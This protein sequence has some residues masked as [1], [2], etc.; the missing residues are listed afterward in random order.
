MRKIGFMQGRL[1]PLVDG[2]IQAFPWS[3]WED[4]FIRGSQ[5]G[6]DLIEWTID[7]ERLHE[8]PL[9]S[10]SGRSTIRHLSDEMRLTVASVTGDC[11]MQAPF[12][13][14]EGSIRRHLLN[15]FNYVLQACEMLGVSFLVVPLVDSGSI[16]NHEQ[17][18]A[19][20]D[21]LMP[22]TYWLLD[23]KISIL[24]ESDFGP[25]E[26]GEMIGQ[27]PS[28]AFGV[29]YDVGNSASLGWN[30]HEEISVYGDRIMNVH[31]KDRLRGGESV[32]LGQ[33]D[34][35]FAMVFGELER[36]SYSGDFILQTARAVDDDHLGALVVYLNMVKG[37][38][39][40]SI[41]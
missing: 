22:W 37:W 4:E 29:N 20:L 26:L 5:A 16:D 9:L 31:V 18:S 28:I 34:A 12:W 10:T 38:L 41:S 32:P 39:K 23:R 19:L 27:F 6:F 25:Q 21:D 35:D 14:A 1:S 40:D 15:E 2:R 30:P 11:F 3:C 7:H 36:V 13:K 33:G 8:N 24:F 17:I